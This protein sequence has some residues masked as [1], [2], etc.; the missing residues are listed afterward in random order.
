MSIYQVGFS[1]ENVGKR[2]EDSKK[3][4]KWVYQV[5]GANHEVEFTWSIRSGKQ[6]VTIDGQNAMFTKKKGRSV[7]DETLNQ[8]AGLP[9]LRLVCAN[10]AP[11]KAHANFRCYELIIDGKPFGT[12]PSIHGNT[13]PEPEV[14]IDSTVD[15]DIMESNDPFFDGP[16]SILDILFPG[17][18]SAAP[19]KNMEI[20]EGM[21]FPENDQ[22]M[23]VADQQAN[24]YA[25]GAQAAP[26][27]QQQA[28]VPV[29]DLLG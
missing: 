3:K 16:M 21:S 5:A 27:D 11:L 29:G 6:D 4:V 25:L 20:E 26:V 10:K 1:V 28:L 9:Q 12:Y 23:V 13:A 7:F 19:A 8:P 14:N 18:Y 24:P 17:K 2:Q 15:G 22:A